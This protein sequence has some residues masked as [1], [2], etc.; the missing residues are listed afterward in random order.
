VKDAKGDNILA[1][2]P[3]VVD[4]IKCAVEIQKGSSRINVK[5]C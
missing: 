5:K 1:D 3:S 2:F 4:A